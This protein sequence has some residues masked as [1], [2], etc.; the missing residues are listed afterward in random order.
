MRRH[1]RDRALL[2]RRSRFQRQKSV[3]FPRRRREYRSEERSESGRGLAR[4][5]P[6]LLFLD[7]TRFATRFLWNATNI[8]VEKRH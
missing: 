4:R 5:V 1:L 8:A 6:R 3:H 7:V 2:P